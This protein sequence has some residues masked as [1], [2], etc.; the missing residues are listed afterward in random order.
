MLPFILRRLKQ[1]VL[2]D[3]PPK[4]TQDFYC[5]LSPLQVQLYEDYA[6]SQLNKKSDSSGAKNDSMKRAPHVFQAL[7]H[8]RRVCNHPKLVLQESSK[9]YDLNEINVAAKLPGNATVC[10]CHTNSFAVTNT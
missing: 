1:D 10:L 9:D 3:L 2:K 8:L 6:Q 7:Q 4:I 5:D